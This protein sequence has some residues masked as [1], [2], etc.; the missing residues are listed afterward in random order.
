[1]EKEVVTAE[2]EYVL[3]EYPEDDDTPKK[4]IIPRKAM[5]SC[6]YCGRKS[7]VEMTT[8][9]LLELGDIEVF[10]CNDYQLKI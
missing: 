2:E 4:A 5:S 3:D 7:D 9:R 10:V 1:M 6:Y 8:V